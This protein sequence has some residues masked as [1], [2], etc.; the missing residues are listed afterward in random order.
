MYLSSTDYHF[1]PSDS[2]GEIAEQISKQFNIVCDWPD[3]IA[4]R[5][6]TEGY[7]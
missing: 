5:L 4:K 7:T 2:G 3:K 6:K 1:S